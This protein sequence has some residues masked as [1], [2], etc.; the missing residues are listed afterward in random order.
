M[1]D[2]NPL[3]Y[4]CTGSIVLRFSW[5]YP[6]FGIFSIQDDHIQLLCVFSSAGERVEGNLEGYGIVEFN[7]GHTYEVRRLLS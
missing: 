2:W 4:T 5:E 6:L 7:D 1:H 3:T